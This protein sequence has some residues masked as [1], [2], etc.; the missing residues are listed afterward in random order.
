MTSKVLTAVRQ[1]MFSTGQ[2]SIPSTMSSAF[3]RDILEI[4]FLSN[5]FIKKLP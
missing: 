3:F 2:W 1:R 4:T 5:I